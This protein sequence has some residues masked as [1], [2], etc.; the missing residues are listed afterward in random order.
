MCDGTAF[1]HTSRTDPADIQ[2]VRKMNVSV[3]IPV[4]NAERYVRTAVT[5]ALSQ[6]EV[7]EVILIEDGSSDS[8]YE[9]CLSLAK[10]ERVRVLR[11]SDGRNHGA[12]AARNPG[13]Q[14]A[15]MPF[16]AF[17]DA[18]DTY[19]PHRFERAKEIFAKHADA[20]GVHESIGTQIYPP[21]SAGDTLVKKIP[22]TTGITISVSP[23]KLFRALA[24]GKYGHIHLDGLVVKK[25]LLVSGMLFDTSLKM[26]EDSDFILRLAAKHRLY[27]GDTSHIVAKRGIHGENSILT[28]PDIMH[29]RRTY[30]QKCIDN[31]FFGTKDLVAQLYIISRR[32]GASNW[33]APF[34]S[35]GKFALPVKLIGI[36]GYLLGRP[37]LLRKLLKGD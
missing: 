26:S 35:L 3:V 5:S 32:V 8:S 11:H 34:R 2:S 24:T 9:I 33:Y 7:K 37:R 29:Y 23:E 18:D 1:H 17:L 25:S 4:Y 13:I 22:A 20:D 16:I 10:D 19:E 31:N 14:S 12:A 27:S 28:S 36:T 30:L 15:Q 21:L 6:P